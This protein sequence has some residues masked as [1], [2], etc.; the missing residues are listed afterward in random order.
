MRVRTLNAS[1]VLVPLG[2]GLPK[3]LPRVPA[4]PVPNGTTMTVTQHA[5][6]SCP[7]RVHLPCASGRA[8]D[9]RFKVRQVVWLGLV[10]LSIILMTSMMQE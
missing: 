5:R 6:R 2:I 9:S 3:S 7:Q 10:V 4:L 1:P 8:H